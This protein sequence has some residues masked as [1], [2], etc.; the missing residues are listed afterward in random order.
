MVAIDDNIFFARLREILAKGWIDIPDRPGYGGTGGPGLLL[1]SLIGINRSNRDGPDTGI[2]ELKYHGGNSPL[3]LFHLTPSPK[4]IM[5]QLV[6]GYGWPDAKDRTS[7]RHTIWGESPLGF[8][9]I[10]EQNKIIVRNIG[11]NADPS[12]ADPYWTHDSLINAFVYKLR[13]L[14]VI[15]GRKS[16][17]RVRYDSARLH[18]EPNIYGFINSIEK[19]L[20]AVDFDARTNLTGSG[21]R[22]HGT[23][24]RIKLDD[25]QH[26]YSESQKFSVSE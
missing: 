23:K 17:N 22:D 24:F 18:S 2:W 14:A 16:K 12:I 7:F 6:R 15:H 11:P 26:L 25:L 21:L 3:T 8:K 4:K 20:I 5:H 10:N 19:G 9:I 1:E 13:R